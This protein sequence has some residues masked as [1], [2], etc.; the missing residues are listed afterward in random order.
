MEQ[1]VQFGIWT[2]LVVEHGSVMGDQELVSSCQR[3]RPVSGHAVPIVTLAQLADLDPNL[4]PGSEAIGA[5]D[6]D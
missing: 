4:E 5:P 1:Q 6:P 3:A 2:Y